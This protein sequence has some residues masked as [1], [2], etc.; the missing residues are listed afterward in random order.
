[1]PI[2]NGI[3]PSFMFQPNLA[4]NA[5]QMNIS[6]IQMPLQQTIDNNQ[7]NFNILNQD[8]I[9]NI[10]FFPSIGGN[11]YVVQS[12]ANDKITDIIEKYRKKANDYNENNFFL[13]VI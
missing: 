11:I 7:N 2:N 10:T 4:V 1:M 6:P 5:P 12:N 9:I 13:M 8:N 3:N